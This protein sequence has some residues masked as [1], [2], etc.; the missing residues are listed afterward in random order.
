MTITE[1]NEIFKYPCVKRMELTF[2]GSGY[3]DIVL[4]NTDICTE[5][6]SLEEALCSDEEIR[7]GACEASCF[8]VRVVNSASFKGKMLYVKMKIVVDDERYL[9]DSQGNRIVTDDGDYIIVNIG[10][11]DDE[12]PI[13]I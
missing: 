12:I 2:K 1:Y 6:M 13:F 5:E 4:T 11:R 8:K 10:E 3:Q 7:Y 9:I